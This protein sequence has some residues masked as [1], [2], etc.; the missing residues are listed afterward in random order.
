[1]R[2]FKSFALGAVSSAL[3]M[4]LVGSALAASGKL[5]IEVNP[6]ISI[7]VNGATFQ[8]K[9]ANGKSVPVFEYNGTT[10]AP[11]RALA[12]AYGLEVGYDAEAKMATVGE[13]S[14]T[15]SETPVVTAS[16][17][18]TTSDIEKSYTQYVYT[19]ANKANDLDSADFKINSGIIL[20][21]SKQAQAF[22]NYD[23]I[24]D[25]IEKTQNEKRIQ[26]VKT[27]LSNYVEEKICYNGS[28]YVSARELLM[29]LSDFA[30]TSLD[31]SAGI[32]TIRL[33]P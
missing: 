28:T 8:P 32:E 23:A 5:T 4:T 21:K 30:D 11:L 12:E 15:S 25:I 24:Y 19:S 33:K 1:M 9:D 26:S 22:M 16:D 18:I 27:F 14:G 10:Y 17:N 6:D 31:T 7:K 3:A 13:L 29:Y 2:N 20:L